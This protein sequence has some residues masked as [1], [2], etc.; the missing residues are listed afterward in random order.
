MLTPG[1]SFRC[2]PVRPADDGVVQRR[3]LEEPQMLEKGVAPEAEVSLLPPISHAHAAA[4]IPADV[5]ALPA[6]PQL[7]RETPVADARI[8]PSYLPAMPGT[9]VVLS[10]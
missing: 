1:M 7:P 2:C 3:G 9:A 8:T 6:R 10:V 5:P 4:H